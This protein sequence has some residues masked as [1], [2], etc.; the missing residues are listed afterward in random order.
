MSGPFDRWF[1]LYHS[2]HIPERPWWCRGTLTFYRCDGVPAI[3]LGH[4]EGPS[5]FATAM[6]R[7]DGERPLP[8][9]PPMCGQSW[10]WVFDDPQRIALAGDESL[11]VA[12]MPDGVV[13]VLRDALGAPGGVPRLAVAYTWPVRG[14]V[15]VG[16]PSIY[17]RDVPWAPPE[18]WL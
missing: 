8:A 6:A 17:G 16:G 7:I 9:P 2:D 18:W 1:Q 4:E 13:M 15:L 3:P 5:G 12:V 10:A 11:V 14:A